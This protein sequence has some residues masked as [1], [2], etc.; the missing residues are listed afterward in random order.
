MATN[1]GTTSMLSVSEA[2]APGAAQPIIM[3]DG[4]TK[5]Y[6]S[7][8]SNA[9]DGISFTV[10]PGTLFALLGP[11][12]AGK[13]TT[14]AILTTILSPTAGTVRI[15]GHDIATEASAVRRNIGIIFQ[16]PSL[17]L[18]LTAEE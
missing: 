13:T 2:A 11:N 10:A 7:A 4:L 15:V 6:R 14:I 17:D 9:V 16:N 3:V 12:G 5:R 8:T 18:N 1:P